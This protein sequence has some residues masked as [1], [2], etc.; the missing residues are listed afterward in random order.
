MLENTFDGGCLNCSFVTNDRDELS[1]HD[2]G[3]SKDYKIT[4]Q[5]VSHLQITIKAANYDEALRIAEYELLAEEFDV[6]GTEFN[7]G[8]VVE[9]NK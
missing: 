9:I 5:F 1:L 2:C 6:V 8:E 3:Q 7:L 4:A